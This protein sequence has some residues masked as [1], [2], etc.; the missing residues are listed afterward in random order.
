M[1]ESKLNGGE[2]HKEAKWE[3]L[4]TKPVNDSDGFTTDYSM[5]YN[6]GEKRWVF[7]FGDSDVYDPTNTDPD[8]ET[9]DPEEAR[10]WFLDYNGFEDIDE[11]LKED[12]YEDTDDNELETAPQKIS[13]AA[14]SISLSS[15]LTPEIPNLPDCLFN[16][17]SICSVVKFSFFIKKVTIDGSISPHLVTI[18]RPAKEVNPNEL[19]TAFPPFIAHTLA[20]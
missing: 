6:D 13:S 10:Q 11:R 17:L 5:W 15:K 20:P 9:E 8:W 3:R 2:N 1:H 16:I 19:S 4:I 12:L 14:T 7:I 18:G